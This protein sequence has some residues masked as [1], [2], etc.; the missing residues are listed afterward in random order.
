MATP[1]CFFKWFSNNIT[2]KASL[3]H[4]VGT[5]VEKRGSTHRE[6]QSQL[7]DAKRLWLYAQSVVSDQRALSASLTEAESNS[8]CCESEAK[9]AVERAARVEA[10]RYVARREA[11]IA[12]IDVDAAGIARAVV[13][14]ELARV[15]HALA[16]SEEAKR[17]EEYEVSRMAVER[18][19]LLLDLGT[20]KDEMSAL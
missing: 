10:E 7:G 2:Q 4:L 1:N 11:S 9:E 3:A 19:S 17:K 13:E 16:F 8:R 15:Q 18:V 5:H 12:R 6:L 14:F 20:S